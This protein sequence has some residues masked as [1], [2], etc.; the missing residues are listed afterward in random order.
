MS[1]VCIFILLTVLP[2]QSPI[3]SDDSASEQAARSKRERLREFY[4][5]EAAGYTIFRDASRQ[6][7]VEL[8][9]EP[10]YVWTNPLRQGGLAG[11]VFVWT[12]R[13]RAEVLGSFWSLQ[14]TGRRRL[15]HEFHSLSLSVLDVERPG[16]HTSSWTP[17]A[18]GIKTTPIAGAPRPARSAAQRLSQIRELTRDF[19]SST[20]DRR[21]RRWELRLLPQPLYRYESTDPDVSDGALFAFVSSDVT[22][23]EALLVIEARKKDGAADPIWHYA[24]A[25]FTDLDLSVR[26]KGKEVFT[27]PLIP[28][29]SIADP[30][31]RYNAF[32]DRDISPVE[33]KAL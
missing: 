32:P 17:R 23:P 29:N 24:I 2:G 15:Y 33:E 28:Y 1:S 16:T 27:A 12:C 3:S 14:A 30:E 9:R 5:G 31:G 4:T 10:V 13:G 7:R 11:A 25:R 20:K 18:P 19:S 26:Y 6:E 21:Q 8:R 22:D